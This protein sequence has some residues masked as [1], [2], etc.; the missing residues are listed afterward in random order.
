MYPK[1][2]WY[3]MCESAEVTDKPF[4][5]TILDQG[6]VAYRTP[7]GEAVVLEDFCP[8]RGLPLSKGTVEGDAIRCG[9]H[10]MLVGRDGACRSMPGQPHI[11]RLKGVRGFPVVEKFG[12]VWVWAGE[13]ER[14]D[15]DRLP[16]LPWGP[17][18]NWTF[19]GGVYRIPCNYQYLIDNL[20][21][22][23]HETYVHP[24][25]IG[26][27]EIDEA[28]PEVSVQDD[29][30]FVKRW[31]LGIKPPPFWANMINTD[32][33]CDRWQICCFVPPTNVLIDV[34]VAV[35]GTGAPQGDRSRGI[36]GMVVDLITPET[37]TSCWYFWGMARNFNIAD[38]AL[39]EQI[40]K[41]QGAV[42]TEDEVILE[43]Q[44]RNL[45][46][47]PERRLV[48]LDIDRGG[49]HVRKVIARLCQAEAV[50]EPQAPPPAA[51]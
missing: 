8:H 27:K 7:A 39:T 41:N 45:L 9:Y 20:M 48:N 3:V 31:M 42:F 29:E 12:Y 30:V 13:A 44:Q 23:T 1:N 50:Q 2:F 24:D 21:D 47:N 40:R 14:A 15:T 37:D 49:S 16:P 36:T 28:K 26:Q 35:A 34:G 46:R 22:L 33:P 11:S 4:A 18:S 51:S 38:Q 6:L 43:A 5:R 32:E 19:G 17:G 25:S 10:G